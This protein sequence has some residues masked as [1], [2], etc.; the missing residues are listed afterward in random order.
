M[1]CAV[2]RRHG[3]CLLLNIRKRMLLLLLWFNFRAG[4]A[5]CIKRIMYVFCALTGE[6]IKMLRASWRR[7]LKD[8]AHFVFLYSFIFLFVV[9][10]VLQTELFFFF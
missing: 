2:K 4:P 3:D 8:L 5:Q 1:K 6:M 7:P 10:F 9:S